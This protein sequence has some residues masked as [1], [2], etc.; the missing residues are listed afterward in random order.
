M[1]ILFVI[2]CL[3]SGGKERR[4]TEL[5]K[6]LKSSSTIE[7][8]LVVMNKDIHYRE[9]LDLG[10]TIHYIIRKTKKD[11]S[12]FFKLYNICKKFKP[13][14]VHCWDDM[15]AV[16]VAPVCK[17]LNI[18]LA[19]GMIVDTPVN[20]NLFNKA[21]LRAKLTFPL[22]D[23][24][25]G[26]SEAGLEAYRAPRKKSVCIHNGMHLERFTKLEKS[27]IVKERILG[28]SCDRQLVLGMAAAF[29]DRKDYYTLIEAAKILLP[30]H[31][32]IRFV[33]IGD[34]KNFN[35]LKES[36]PE[37][38]R[39]KLL[40]LGKRSEIEAIINIF[41][42]GIMLT[43]TKM[44]GEGIS[45]SILEYMA[46]GK[47]VIATRGGGTTELVSDG[48]NGFLIEGGDTIRLIEKIELLINNA[49]LR[50]ELGKNGRNL[51]QH[52][53]EINQMTQKYI[54]QYSL[55]IN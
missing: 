35:S 33:F 6:M 47:P 5:M 42:I 2:D 9:V 16:Y 43:N 24:I 13:E 25:I 44:H 27:E 4:L 28:E 52:N 54:S 20:F 49:E 10:I 18:K 17:I 48:V 46:L 23:L 30:Q 55:L 12:V 3:A 7:F 15:T 22:S 50:T 21:W 41:D 32:N 37:A 11:I 53:F 34:G 40:F 38:F 1:K 36:I 14:I 26:N 29:E 31:E 51:I 19:N 39:S 8:E 45:N